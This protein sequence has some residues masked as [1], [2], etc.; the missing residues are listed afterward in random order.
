M[1]NEYPKAS[2]LLGEVVAAKPDEMTLYYP[3]A[4]SLSKQGKMEATNR[5]TRQMVPSAATP[6]SSISCSARPYD[7]QGDSAK[8]PR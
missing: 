6:L 8:S 4:L 7:E 1:M 5:F 2:V 3:L